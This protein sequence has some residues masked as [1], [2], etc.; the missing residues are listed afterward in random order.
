M[1]NPALHLRMRI[2]HT[3]YAGTVASKLFYSFPPVFS[4]WGRGG[5]RRRRELCV[6]E[7]QGQTLGL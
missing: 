5:V 4:I 3:A 6:W 1:H 7:A 2:P